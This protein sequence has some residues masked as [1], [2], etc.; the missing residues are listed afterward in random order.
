MLPDRET[1]MLEEDPEEE[2]DRNS[3]KKGQKLY[4]KMQRRSMETMEE[5]VP[6]SIT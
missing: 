3:W 1:V 6:D 4:W 5:G 2:G